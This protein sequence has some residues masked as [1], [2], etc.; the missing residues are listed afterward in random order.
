MYRSF[1]GTVKFEITTFKNLEILTLWCDYWKEMYAV[2]K[3]KQRL[4]VFVLYEGTFL[5]LE[6]LSMLYKK[7]FTP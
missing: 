5:Y 3:A 7:Q 4:S 2:N 6:N 1:L